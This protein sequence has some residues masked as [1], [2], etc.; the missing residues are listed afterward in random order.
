MPYPPMRISRTELWSPQSAGQFN[1]EP[2]DPQITIPPQRQSLTIAGFIE[3][4]SDYHDGL[5]LVHKI[6]SAIH[7][8]GGRAACSLTSSAPGM[9]PASRTPP[10][11]ENERSQLIIKE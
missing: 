2:S 10:G 11:Q 9:R 6:S 7:A 3:A 1:L 5:D 4:Y 8:N